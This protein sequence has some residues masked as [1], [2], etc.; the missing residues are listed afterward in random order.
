MFK[1][2][3]LEAELTFFAFFAFYAFEYP[4]LSSVVCPSRHRWQDM[5]IEKLDGLA[6]IDA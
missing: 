2:T 3:T 5:T 1:R 4:P 6:L